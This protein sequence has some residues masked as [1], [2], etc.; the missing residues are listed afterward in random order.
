MRMDGR[1]DT[2]DEFESRFLQLAKV[3]KI[4]R[5]GHTVYSVFMGLK[6]RLF[7]YKELT[8]WFL[9]QRRSVFTARYE[10]IQIQ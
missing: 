1:T 3:L 6:R 2:Q 8:D 9:Q 5:S 10:L 4:L 7:P